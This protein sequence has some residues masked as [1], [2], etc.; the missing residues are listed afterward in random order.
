MHC[1]SQPCRCRHRRGFGCNPAEDDR[2]RGTAIL[3]LGPRM[4]DAYTYAIITKDSDL[5]DLCQL[6]V[7][8]AMRGETGPGE[9]GQGERDT[10]SSGTWCSSSRSSSLLAAPAHQ[11]GRLSGPPGRSSSC[12]SQHMGAPPSD[13]EA[14]QQKHAPTKC[15]LERRRNAVQDA[16]VKG[17]Q[18]TACRPEKV[19]SKG[20]PST[21]HS[22][23]TIPQAGDRYDEGH[24]CFNLHAAHLPLLLL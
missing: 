19:E 20:S 22:A 5:W 6:A 21:E 10:H 13:V 24:T 8:N 14:G 4:H 9:A 3:H 15:L 2:P 23:G 1:H 17:Q 11:R 16:V 12:P 7:V 18:G